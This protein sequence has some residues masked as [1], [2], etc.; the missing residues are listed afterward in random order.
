MKHLINFNQYSRL[1]EAVEVEVINPADYEK[2][3]VP[4]LPYSNEIKS[5]KE[6]FL[7]KITY[8]SKKLNADPK[9]LMII[10]SGES[11]FRPDATNA[12][13]GAT[14]LI[15]FMPSVIKGYLDPK[16]KEPL[17]TDQLK[18]MS[19]LDQLDVVYAYYKQWM[20]ILKIQKFNLPGDFFGV[21]FYPKV[22]T[23]GMD[24]K[25]PQ[26]V[27]N[28]NKSYFARIGGITK[29]AYYDYC[30]KLANDPESM[31]AAISSFDKEGFQGEG[32]GATSSPSLMGAADSEESGLGKIVG[33]VLKDIGKKMGVI[34]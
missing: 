20:S 19:A 34:N 2:E 17:N 33:G 28:Q 4:A 31:K 32:S 7:K 14:G 11:G 10:I 16:T 18:K 8:I 29:K 15:Q 23:E 25:F 9:W 21:T 22:V 5:D 12:N 30:Q 13:G 24:F 27:V 3:T 6:K 26:N 1:N